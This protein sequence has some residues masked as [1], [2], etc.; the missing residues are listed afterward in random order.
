MLL[1]SSA[2]R[3]LYFMAQNF[4]FKNRDILFQDTGKR[5]DQD[6]VDNESR[7]ETK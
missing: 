3:Y 7:K 5:N 2:C 6:Q 4:A 1:G